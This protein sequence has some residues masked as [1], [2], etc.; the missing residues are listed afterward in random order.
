M[1][2]S[3]GFVPITK[4]DKT[5]EGTLIVTGV[6]TDSSLDRSYQ[7]A[8]PDW[9]NK[10]MPQWFRDGGNIREQ[11]DGKRAAGVAFEYVKNDSGQHVITTEIV[12]PITI[13]K[14]EKKVLT[15]FSFGATNCRI[16]TDKSALGGRI[17]DGV[18]N[19]VSVVDRPCNA[20]SV[21]T[22]AKSDEGG[23]LKLIEEPTLEESTE[24]TEEPTFTPSQFADLLKNL[25]KVPSLPATPVVEEVV[26]VTKTDTQVSAEKIVEDLTPFIGIEKTE[27]DPNID[28]AKVAIASI[29]RLI[30]A[31]ANSLAAGNLNEIYDIQTLTEAACSLQWFVCN[32]RWEDEVDMADESDVTKT[33][34]APP[35][36]DATPEPAP[37]EQEVAKSESQSDEVTEVGTLN[38]ADITALLEEAITKAVQPYKDEVA[39]IKAEMA[40]VLE[41]PV[42]GGPARTRTVVQKASAEKMDTARKEI[43]YLQK[44]VS[45]SGGDLRKGYYERLTVAE[46]NLLKLDGQ[47]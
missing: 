17:I 39:L 22:I 24:K 9:L 40:Q 6:A 3:Y 13:K 38:K 47:A 46:S 36:A 14:I 2:D 42:A 35:V 11:H 28:A 19:E 20:N 29:A 5:D 10:A 37:V 27:D 21:F 7:I 25:G 34:V 30:V 15:G 23:E 44:M 31:E 41:T 8:D 1:A 4:F 43:E 12:D 33:E 26:V 32:E 45:V 18:I 16:T